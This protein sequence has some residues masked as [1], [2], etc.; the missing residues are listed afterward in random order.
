M[1]A[2]KFMNVVRFKFRPKCVNQYFEVQEKFICEGFFKN[3]LHKHE[4]IIIA[5]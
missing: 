5:L 1:T 4:K 3:T 2:H